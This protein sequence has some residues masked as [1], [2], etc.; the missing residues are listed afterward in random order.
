MLTGFLPEPEKRILLIKKTASF[1]FMAGIL[2]SFNVWRSDR[3]FPLAPVFDFLPQ[4]RAPFD[5]VPVG[6]LLLLLTANCFTTKKA[7]NHLVLA[8]VLVLILQDQNRLQPWVYIYALCLLPFSFFRTNQ[9][10]SASHLTYFQLLLTGIYCW[11][12]IHKLNP[13]FIEF[14]FQRILTDLF[15]LS[16]PQLL[17]SLKPLGYAIPLLEIITGL[18]LL[19]PRTRKAGF[20][21][22][23]AA[24]LFILVYL[25]PLGIN[26]NNVVYP[27]NLAMIALVYFACFGIKNPVSLKAETLPLKMLTLFM[28]AIAWILPVL[29]FFGYWDHYLAFSLYS[30]KISEHYIIVAESALPEIDKRLPAYFLQDNNLQGGQIIDVNKWAMGEMNVPFYPERRVF[31]KIC[32]PFCGLNIPEGNLFFLEFEKPFEKGK[33]YRFT[34]KE[35]D[36]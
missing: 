28:V 16:D 10:F 14:T 12:G 11:S 8:L 1:F 32:K 31:E 23:A 13:N 7:V 25:S 27:W 15:R 4:L 20:F 6:L 24:H 35:L 33:F 21:L 26:S 30:E 9:S 19:M 18:A 22:A 36:Q 34:C 17:N 29:N 5:L 3:F 2:L